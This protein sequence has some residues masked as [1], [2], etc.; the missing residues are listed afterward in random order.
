MKCYRVYSSAN[1]TRFTKKTVEKNQGTLSA[2]EALCD[3]ALYK[4]TF[5]LHLH[6][7]ALDCADVARVYT[8]STTTLPDSAAAER[9]FSTAAEVL[10]VRLCR[11]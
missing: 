10:T 1:E 4:S 5:T 3:Y 11:K 6:Y 2:L 9:V 8:N 7:I